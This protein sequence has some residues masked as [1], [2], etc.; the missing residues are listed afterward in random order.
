LK[1]VVVD[2]SLLVAGLFKDGSVRDTLLNSED[3]AFS[4]PLYVREETARQIPRVVSRSRLP[5][6]T[7]EAVLEDLLSA[8]D[9]VPPGVYSAWMNTARVLA[10]RADAAK[11]EDYIALALALEAPVWTLDRDFARVPGLRRL[12]T[13][14]LELI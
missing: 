2:A 8:I 13:K 11:D 12:S 1:R 5:R 7:V 9:L 6:D 10:R 14:D 3:L 4:A